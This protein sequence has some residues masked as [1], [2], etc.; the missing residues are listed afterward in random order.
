MLIVHW[1]LANPVKNYHGITEVEYLIDS[2]GIA[3][4]RAQNKGRN[5]CSFVAI[6]LVREMVV[7]S[8]ECYHP[9]ENDYS[10]R[11]EIKSKTIGL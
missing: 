10:Y 4:K 8:L 6:W 7:D 2:N 9:A 1:N 11:S 3:E 5:F